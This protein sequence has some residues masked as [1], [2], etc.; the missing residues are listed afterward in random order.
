MPAGMP[1]AALAFIGSSERAA[2]TGG[3]GTGVASL[4]GTATAGNA[5]AA[6]RTTPTQISR[7][8]PNTMAMHRPRFSS[9]SPLAE[10]SACFTPIIVTT[11]RTLELTVLYDV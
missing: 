1:K 8:R 2:M 11:P 4:V 9:W 6:T 3:L 5:P 10:A 7:N